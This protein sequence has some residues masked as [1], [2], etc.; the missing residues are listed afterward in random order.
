[1]GLRGAA[2]APRPG[3]VPCAL[4]ARRPARP[5]WLPP[6][7]AAPSGARLAVSLNGRPSLAATTNT[8][9]LYPTGVQARAAAYP[10]DQWHA[11]DVA[12]SA[13]RAGNNTVSVSVSVGDQ[14]GAGEDFSITVLHL[15]LALP[16][17]GIN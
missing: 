8:S 5:T 10:A 1:M 14:A 15:D 12:P 6:S 7:A 4:A 9:S 13:V 11:W 16:V 3:A 2:A 17:D